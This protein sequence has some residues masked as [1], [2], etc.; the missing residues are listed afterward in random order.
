MEFVIDEELRSLIPPLSQEE[1]AQLEQNIL[2]FGCLDALR[3]WPIPDSDEIILLDGHNRFKICS[4]HNVNYDTESI[5]LIDRAAAIDWMI[6]NQ[7]G[8]RNLS[9]KQ[10]S[11]LRGRQY[12]QERQEITNPEGV[13][14]KTGKIVIPQNAG[15][16]SEHTAARIAKHHGVNKATIERDAE[17]AKAVDA[18]VAATAPDV[19][20]QI[21]GGDSKLTKL[22]TLKLA[23]FAKKNP[24]AMPDILEE[25]RQAPNKTTASA[26]VRESISKTRETPSN[27]DAVRID[28]DNAADAI[29]WLKRRFSPDELEALCD[30]D[31]DEANEED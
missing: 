19:K 5:M 4:E 14:G 30:E 8:R 20:Q 26:I 29:N 2:E 18:I 6:D 22:A 24:A 15:Q 3:V 1:Y 28:F 17:Y 12:Q 9:A 21:L 23:E 31:F 10:I 13:G 7:L 11:Y 27:E 25:V 16:Q